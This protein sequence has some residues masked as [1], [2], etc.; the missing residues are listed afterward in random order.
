MIGLTPAF[1]R[2]FIEPD[3]AEEIS[4]IGDGDSGHS[5]F[6]GGLGER[7]VIDG[8]VEQAEPG[9]QMEMDELRHV[10]RSSADPSIPT[11]SLRAA[12]T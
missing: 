5:V 10:L 9:M 3:R 1:V 2:G 8:A 12:W 7:V 11:Q 6:R 4:M